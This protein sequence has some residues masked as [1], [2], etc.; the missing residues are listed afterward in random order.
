MW[1]SKIKVLFRNTYS[2]LLYLYRSSVN[3]SMIK[4]NINNFYNSCLLPLFHP[5]PILILKPLLELVKSYNFWVYIYSALNLILSK[6]NF[7]KRQS[8]SILKWSEWNSKRE[9]Y[10]NILK[11]P[12]YF[13]RTQYCLYQTMKLHKL[14]SWVWQFTFISR[15]SLCIIINIK[16]L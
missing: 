15:S 7:I 6:Q 14:R 13:T 8:N 9:E 2:T 1:K 12:K 11:Q 3:S 10:L 5:P 4:H 16:V